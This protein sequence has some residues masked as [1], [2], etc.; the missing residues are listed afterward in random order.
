M[1]MC[2][3]LNGYLA[4]KKA[5]KCGKPAIAFV[6]GCVYETLVNMDSV[7]K[8]MAA[9][10]MMK[11]IK[12]MTK[13]SDYVHYVDDS[14]YNK[15]PTNN[16]YLICSDVAIEIDEDVIAK[17][18]KKIEKDNKPIV[19]GLIGYTHNRI[20]GIDTAIRAFS[21]LG[22][23]HKLQVVGRGDHTWLDKIARE[24]KIEHKIEFLGI[25]NGR[26]EVFEW[27]DSIDIYLQ[28]SLTEG[29][30][31]ATIE[32]MSRGCPVISTSVG[33]ILEH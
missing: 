22:E 18:A 19:V 1:V 6:G 4:Y 33:A 23:D 14:L 8:R 17:R 15:Y 16:K 31:R 10:I 13:N 24:L 20:K 29:M 28:P 21:M 25:L 9:P 26:S 2:F 5:K 27:L 7:L 11:M 30:P 3:G 12:D 32:A